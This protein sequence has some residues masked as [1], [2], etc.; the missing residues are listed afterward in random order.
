MLRDE[1]INA[2]VRPIRPATSVPVHPQIHGREEKAVQ[3]VSDQVRKLKTGLERNVKEQ[4]FANNL[5]MHRLFEHAAVLINRHQVSHDGKVAYRRIH[6]RQTF[7]SQLE[8][9]EQVM[10]KLALKRTK[11]K[12]GPPFAP[13][14]T[15]AISVGVHKAIVENVV[16]PQSGRTVRA[17]TVHKRPDE[18][19]WS[20]EKMLQIKATLACPN[21]GRLGEG[22]VILKP[23]IDQRGASGKDFPETFHQNVE[24]FEKGL[25]NDKEIGRGARVH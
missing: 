3:D 5:L 13:R 20:F 16:V 8:F 14:S 18:E 2:K 23:E 6:Q 12:R 25:H 10:A 24:A 4:M 22:I 9:G 21:P 19:R 7:A 11:T 15:L 1:V 17:R